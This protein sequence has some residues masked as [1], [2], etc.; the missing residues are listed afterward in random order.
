MAGD[1]L[2]RGA[3]GLGDGAIGAAYLVRVFIRQQGGVAASDGQAG[4]AAL[5][6]RAHAVVEPLG[7]VVEARVGCQAIAHQ[8][9]FVV[10]VERGHERSAGAIGLLGDAARKGNAVER[11]GHQQFLALTQAQADAHGN[12]GQE[13]EFLF[14]GALGGGDGGGAHIFFP[15]H[16]L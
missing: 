14:V 15:R 5:E 9:G 16:S 2:K 1:E 7:G 13:I 3:I 4:G 12:L 8:S 10:A 11:G 6:G